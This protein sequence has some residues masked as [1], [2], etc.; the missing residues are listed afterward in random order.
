M[1][2]LSLHPNHD[3]YFQRAIQLAAK[4]GLGEQSGG[5]FG[6]V[7]VCTLTGDIIGEGYNQVK[8]QCDPTWHA[9][10]HAIRDACRFKQTHKLADC[11]MYCSC[12]PSKLGVQAALH[13]N[14]KEICVAYKTDT[15]D[16]SRTIEPTI[17]YFDK[18]S[19]QVVELLLQVKQFET[20]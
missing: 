8:K 15:V 3:V 4:A 17:S 14:I 13:A 9:E 12:T 20:L 5:C 2:N 16:E 10:L 1:Q 6:A 19:E 18:Y 11:V 7:V